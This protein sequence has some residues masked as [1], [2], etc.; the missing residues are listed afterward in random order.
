MGA[1]APEEVTG[2]LQ[3]WCHGD[4]AA[5]DQIIPLVHNELHRLAHQYMVREPAGHVLQ[6]TA[7]I[8]EAY[9]RLI[10]AS[11]VEW[12]NRVHFFA[13]SANLMRRILVDFA[14]S[15]RYK[16]RR[17]SAW[18]RKIGKNRSKSVTGYSFTNSTADILLPTRPVNRGK[19]SLSPI[20]PIFAH[21]TGKSGKE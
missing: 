11:R 14:R 3:A 12:Q 17:A 16:K 6:T 10:D 21:E 19:S 8:N 4:R 2:L 5:L 20:L 9:M 13:I 15:R 18:N 7:L 1:N